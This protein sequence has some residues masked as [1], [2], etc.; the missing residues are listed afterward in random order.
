MRFPIAMFDCQRVCI[1]GTSPSMNL[2]LAIL[3]VRFVIQRFH[4]DRRFQLPC[5]K[6][7]KTVV[8]SQYQASIKPGSL[9]YLPCRNYI[10]IWNYDKW[11][12]G[13]SYGFV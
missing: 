2:E 4:P 13:D 11:K 1:M 7:G 10:I 12:N 9:Q 5:F 8:S 6:R 3:S